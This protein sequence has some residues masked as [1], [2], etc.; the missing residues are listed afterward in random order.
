MLGRG[1]V[2]HPRVG[3]LGAPGGSLGLWRRLLQVSEQRQLTE[4]GTEGQGQLPGVQARIQGLK[5]QHPLQADLPSLERCLRESHP[6]LS[7]HLQLA[8]LFQ[9]WQSGQRRAVPDVQ[10]SLKG[11]EGRPKGHQV[12]KSVQGDPV[13]DPEALRQIIQPRL[14]A[15]DQ[16]AEDEAIGQALVQE[17]R[18][19]CPETIV[20]LGSALAR[21]GPDPGVGQTETN[22]QGQGAAGLQGHQ[23]GRVD[24]PPPAGPEQSRPQVIPVRRTGEGTGNLHGIRW[25][26]QD[27]QGLDPSSRW[28]LCLREYGLD[29]WGLHLECQERADRGPKGIEVMEREGFGGIGWNHIALEVSGDTFHHLPLTLT[30]TDEPGA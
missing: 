4:A 14:I 29:F 24:L 11:L 13:G 10:P 23:R 16:L 3:F 21:E 27:D 20:L 12:R 30:V 9:R 5:A 15:E 7:I 18:R 28:S 26:A 22:P 19:R 8:Q 17:V 1:E 2:R 25:I 6:G